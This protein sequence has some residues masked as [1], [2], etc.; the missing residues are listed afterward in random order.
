MSTFSTPTNQ[1]LNATPHY[2]TITGVV[3]RLTFHS[4]ES[5]YTVA[6]LKTSRSTDLTTIVGSFANIQPGQTLQLTGFWKDHPQYGPQFQVTKYHE[7]KPA[8]LTGIEK[9]LGSGLIKGVGPITAKR[10]VAHFG[11][12]TLD[13]I[14]NQ[15]DRL[16]EV[17]GIAKKR[18][19][20]IKNAWSTQKA[21]KEVMVF[22]QS[23]GVSTTYA[24]KIYKQYQDN[25][26]A[27][28]TSNP[29]QLATD[30]YGIG[31]L[32]ADKIARNLGVPTDSSFRYC[33][34]IIHALSEAAEDGHCYLPQPELIEKVAK[35]LTTDDHQP[36][37]LAI[38]DIIKQMGAK[39]ELIREIVR[40]NDGEKLLLCY[41]PTFF[42]TEMNLAQ[43]ISRRL[44]QPIVQDMP[45]VRAWIERFTI[46][47]KIQ[48]SPQ[49]Q[50]AVEKAAYSPVMV[51]TG[52]PGVGKTFTTHTIVSLW[53]AMG[54]SIALA[55]PTGRAAQRLA[56]MTLLEAKTIHRLLE[57]DPKTMGFKRDHENPLPHN[58]IIADEASMLDL[59]LAHSLVKA[60]AQ[61]AQLLLVGDIDQ[62]PSVGPGKVLA[63]L[64]NSLR[65]P[66]VRLTQVFRQ[67]QQS[68]I[69]IAAHQ[70]NS[71][72]YPTMEPISDNPVSDCLWH[73]GGH[74]PEHGVQA[75][76][77]LVS[78]FIP[79]LGFNP[80]T[81]VQVLS[82][83]SRG[84]V[85]THNL[86]AVLQQLIN[87]PAPLKVEINR[88]GM[89]LRVGDR[90]IQQMNDYEREVFNGDLGTIV[91]IDTEEQEVTVEYSGRPVVYDYADL[92]EITLA[93]SISIHKSQGSE[94]P[95]VILPLYMQHYMM[96]SRNLFYTGITRAR[97]LA[98]VVGSKKAISLAVRT[99]NDQQ[100]YTRLW[101]RLLQP[102]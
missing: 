36:T 27:T 85:G 81:D 49:Q 12:E 1:P 32:S 3:E 19:K 13:I 40:G 78:E 47:R 67:A 99:T 23:H 41:K 83:M 48:L 102:S 74:Q 29:Y 65:V 62:L 77:E 21:I 98:I 89:I 73:G 84:L 37:E 8:T 71:C 5:G 14:E 97:K 52:G 55:A 68:A 7:T 76:C 43:M 93:W 100:R 82:P 4:E 2:E 60:V 45:R 35:L 33:A 10:I 38:A 17:Q 66:V 42:H 30:I 22:L 57:F 51:L 91:D 69:V 50:Q 6:R 80:A 96:L 75:I 53:K 95:V 70:I 39:E 11:L 87:P 86:N 64:I 54:K 101:Q 94:Y 44:S 58:A 16:I 26:I 59:F 88:G 18:I 92:N 9:Y 61:G 15:I 34:G 20:L 63:D 90:V 56:Y 24:V 31:F 28:V 25:A 79:R 46:S 72:D